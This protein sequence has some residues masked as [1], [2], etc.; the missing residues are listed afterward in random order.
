MKDP[1]FLFYPNDYMGGTMGMTFEE[2]GAYMD[3]LVLQFNKGAFS[4]DQARKL[5]NGSFEKVWP[6]L[7]EKFTE[8]DGKFS[9]K[10][11]EDEK[12]KRASFSESRRKNRT[13]K[14]TSKSHDNTSDEHMTSHMENENE[15]IIETVLGKDKG[16][17]KG[18]PKIDENLPIP[19]HILE[20]AEMNQYTL[21]K[22]KHTEFVKSQWGVFLKERN[23]DPPVKR[24]LYIRQPAELYQYFLNWIRNKKPVNGTNRQI[25]SGSKS[26]SKTAG[27]NRLAEDLLE[28]I[29]SDA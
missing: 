12:T 14:N 6:A 9:N 17:G 29:R 2:K 27:A 15:N 1:A 4:I 16:A 23:N 10:R 20:A 24:M 19:G 7:S 13:S 25:N 3:L 5:L 18:K 22:N 26:N 21:H 11:L 8:A 28:N